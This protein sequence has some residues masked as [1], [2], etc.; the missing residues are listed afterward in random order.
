MKRKLK[1]AV[2]ID[3]WFPFQGGGQEHVR[4]IIQ[5]LSKDC[6]FRI[7]H[8]PIPTSLA[9]AIWS[10]L[11]IPQVILD[12]WHERYDLLHAHAFIAGLPGKILS[13]LLGIPVVYT[14]HGSHT[15]DLAALKK[16]KPSLSINISRG[17][18]ELEKL[19]LTGIRYSRQITVSSS[20]L[21]YQNTNT[22]IAVISNGV[23][24]M[25]FDRVKVK[26]EKD[27]TLI[28]VGK[29]GQ[30]KG[31]TFFNQA[32]AQVKRKYPMIAVKQILGEISNRQ[33]IIRAYKSSHLFVLPSLAEGQP[34]SLLEAWAAKLPVIV[35]KVGDNP[36]MVKDG[37][38]GFLV[39]PA[40]TQTLITAIIQAYK[41]P[42]LDKIGQ[43]GYNLVKKNYT[44]QKTAKATLKLYKEVI[45]ATR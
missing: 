36:K 21:T 20:F 23:D 30:I 3:A 25:E 6:R 12:H 9:R 27:F 8:A 29:R 2:L 37:I 17:K 26:K 7:Y 33:E 28:F 40:D 13:L 11:V 22:N 19:L 35:T 24:V 16:M 1:V 42:K 15:L 18:Y 38:N 41:N 39:P 5:C 43:A 10:F 45:H 32:T 44:W 4:R 31:E 14:V 34:I